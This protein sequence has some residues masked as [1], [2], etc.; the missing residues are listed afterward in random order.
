MSSQICYIM[1]HRRGPIQ[2]A[3]VQEKKMKAKPEDHGRSP[4]SRSRRRKRLPAAAAAAT[5]VML[6]FLPPLT[7]SFVLQP[8]SM[9]LGQALRCVGARQ[10]P[11]FHCSGE[12]PARERFLRS[13]RRVSRHRLVSTEEIIFYVS[14]VLFFPELASQIKIQMNSK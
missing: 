11:W 7:T 1:M 4:M 3:T 2:P 13:S 14:L 6:T 5:V 9:L 8:S 10:S 12:P